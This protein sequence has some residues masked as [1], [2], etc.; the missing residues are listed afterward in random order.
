MVKQTLKEKIISESITSLQSEGLK[1]SLDGIAKKLKISKKT[2]YKYFPDKGA[3][4]KA[5]YEEF[6]GRAFEK[7]DRET[8]CP[9]AARTLL[10]LYC[11][12]RYLISEGIFNKYSLNME[13]KEHTTALNDRLWQK[14]I[15]FLPTRLSDK[16]GIKLIIDGAV[17][18]CYA[19]SQPLS[20]IIK[21]LEE[22]LCL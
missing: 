8:D 21:T 22:L 14:A 4:A 5:I 7:A 18:R 11:K 2:I 6:Y 12:S 15:R 20:K 17:E 19:M 16:E 10:S 13:L 9:N 1:F 3:L